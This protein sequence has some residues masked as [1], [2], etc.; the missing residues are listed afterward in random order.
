MRFQIKEEW[1]LEGGLC[2]AGTVLD[3]S[4]SDRWSKLAKSKGKTI[5]LSAIPL[6]EHAWAEQVRLYAA[7]YGH[8]LGGGWR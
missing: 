3:F 6:D 2:P 7:D 4:K 8:L 1:S 5:P